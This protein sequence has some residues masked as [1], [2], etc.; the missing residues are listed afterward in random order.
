MRQ[1]QDTWRESRKRVLDYFKRALEGVPLIRLERRLA[2]VSIALQS[3]ESLDD[4]SGLRRAYFR[5][6]E[7]ERPELRAAWG[8]FC[9]MVPDILARLPG[10]TQREGLLWHEVLA[11]FLASEIPPG[12][13]PSTRWTYRVAISPA[14]RRMQSLTDSTSLGRYH[15][16]E[17]AARSSERRKF[18]TAW[19]AFRQFCESRGM[20]VAELYELPLGRPARVVLLPPPLAEAHAAFGSDLA[21]DPKIGAITKKAYLAVIG[22]ALQ[23]VNSLTDVAAIQHLLNDTPRGRKLRSAWLRFEFCCRSRGWRV[24][25]LE[26]VDALAWSAEASRGAGHADIC[27]QQELVVSESIASHVEAHEPIVILP[28]RDEPD[29]AIAELEALRYQEGSEVASPAKL[30]VAERVLQLGDCYEA[31]RAAEAESARQ[32]GKR[33]MHAGEM[34]QRYFQDLYER[35]RC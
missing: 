25:C 20:P 3:M 31:L 8:D 33:A 19:R 12:I 22:A 23:K 30:D 32:E 1:A 17:T 2:R 29:D 27:E 34:R 11:E 28:R 10:S 6:A 15:D 9:S 14:L 26:E 4:H 24:V 18:R 7:R 16:V 35:E 5:V 13:G 21:T